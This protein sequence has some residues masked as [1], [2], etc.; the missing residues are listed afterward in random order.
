MHSINT[1]GRTDTF[2]VRPV[3]AVRMAVHVAAGNSFRWVIEKT[4]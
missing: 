1:T 3:L 4:I 2:T